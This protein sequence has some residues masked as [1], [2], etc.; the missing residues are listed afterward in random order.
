V[1]T[2]GTVSHTG[3]GGLTLG[4]G[5]GRVARRFGLACDNVRAVDIV[6]ADGRLV[7][8]SADENPDLYWGV[9]GGGGNFGVVTS[10]EFT[11]HEMARQVIGGPLIFPIERA[12]DLLHAYAEITATAPAEMYVDVF[13]VDPGGD[14]PGVFTF[15]TCYSG[16]PE[17]A[18]RAFAPLRKL[19]TPLV[20]R[21]KPVDYV[22]LQR[23]N[24]ELDP[25]NQ[26]SY[27]KSGFIDSFPD[28][29]VRQLVQGFEPHP[30]RTTM[31]FFQHAGGAISKVPVHATAFPHRHATLNMLSQVVWPVSVDA[32]PHIKYEKAYWAGLERYTDGYYTNEV[33]D[34]GQRV[35]DENYQDN[36]PRLQQIKNKYDPR[37]LFRL[38]ANVKPTV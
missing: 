19:G 14:K 38:N 13:M 36:L 2:A 24:D 15:D 12:R 31:V 16:A 10:F 7:H 21:I 26:G 28:E 1:T 8:A 6:T 5:F 32:A 34:E 3:V 18:D 33:G 27:L 25:R 30:D 11:L 20:D 4:A 37:N 9:R 22:A 23:S 29:L 17:K 35:I